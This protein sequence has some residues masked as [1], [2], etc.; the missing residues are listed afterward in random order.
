M[1]VVGLELA[2][3][4][5]EPIMVVGFIVVV[6]ESGEGVVEIMGVAFIVVVLESGEGVVEISGEAVVVWVVDCYKTV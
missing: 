4:L 5:V 6:L 1:V 3:V 2:A